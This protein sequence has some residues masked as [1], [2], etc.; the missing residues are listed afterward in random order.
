MPKKSANP[1]AADKTSEY[2]IKIDMANSDDTKIVSIDKF[3]KPVS[4]FACGVKIQI[5]CLVYLSSFELTEKKGFIK[6]PFDCW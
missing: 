5:L 3:T 4:T 6:A 1:T 2:R